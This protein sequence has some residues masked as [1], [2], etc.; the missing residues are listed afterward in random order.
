[1]LHSEIE[2]SPI[3]FHFQIVPSESI[4]VEILKRSAFILKS[5]NMDFIGI[6]HWKGSKY[7]TNQIFLF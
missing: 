5:I 1:M 6:L 7:E 3:S 2:F 4:L